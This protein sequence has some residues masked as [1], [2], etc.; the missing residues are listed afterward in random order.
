MSE[1]RTLL[2]AAVLRDDAAERT[3]II[4]V[5]TGQPDLVVTGGMFRQAVQA[6]AA[7]LR[8]RGI[9]AGDLIIIA[10]TQG[11]ESIYAFWGALLIGAVPSMFPTL[12]EKLDPDYYLGNLAELVR[13]SE[14]RAVFTTA[15][16]APTMRE[17]VACEVFAELIPTPTP[18]QRIGEGQ[19]EGNADTIAFLQHSSGTT[20]L[21]KGVALS[22][23]AVMQHL[24]DYARAIALTRD[25]V[26][27]SW[28]PLYH[29]MG[30]IA[31]FLLPLVMGVPLVLMSPFDWVAHPAMLLRAIHAQGGTLCWLPN[32]AYSH[33]ARR[34]RQRDLDGLSLATMRMFI[35][36]SEPVYHETHQAFLERFAALGVREAMLAVSYAMAENTFAVTQTLPQQPPRLDV[37]ERAALERGYAQPVLPDAAGS[38]VKVSCGAPMAGVGVKVLREADGGWQPLAERQVGELFVRSETMLTAY[39]RRPDLQ[40]FVE[41]WYRTGDMGYMAD[42]EV[43]IVGRVKDLIIHAGKNIYPQDIEAIVNTVAG[44]HAGRAV[45]FGVAD[46]REGTELL[47]VIAEVDEAALAQRAEMTA[48]IRAAV[49]RAAEV[50]VAYVHLVDARWLIKTSSGKISRAA[51][52]EKWLRERK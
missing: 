33:L 28:L 50:S 30:L 46:A 13:F 45:V 23:R 36:C 7:G 12:T 47:A 16:F 6:T 8:E 43:Y 39:Y 42:G 32:F 19:G 29:D 18:P 14:V 34:V 26:I 37:V 3:A 1:A 25:D 17:R 51:N 40:P 24:A 49:A 52:R 22:H 38:V 35:N 27:V 21:Q 4:Y 20:G 9:G 41:G 11:M 10:H 48:A 2:D 44:V 5:E 15:A 31:G